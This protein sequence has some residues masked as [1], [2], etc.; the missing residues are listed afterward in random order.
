MGRQGFIRYC[1]ALLLLCGCAWAQTWSFAVSGDSRN[2]GDI[3]M[4]SIAAGA[5]QNG[6]AF[7]WHLGDFRAMYAI[8]EDIGGGKTPADLK[9]YREMAWGDFELHELGPFAGLPLFLARGNHEEA[10]G[11][12]RA[13]YVAEFSSWL[14]QPVIREQ[15]LRDD[16]TD[17]SPH[18]YYH[19]IQGGIDFIA[20]DNGSGVDFEPVQLAWFEKVLDR[21][22]RNA[23]V[24]TLVVGMHRALPDSLSAG[25]SMNDTPEGTTSGRKAY[26]DLL[27]FRKNSGKKVYVLAS[28]SHFVM[29][30]LYNTACRREHPDEILP[31]WLIGT[32]G[33][34]RYR[35]PPDH[36]AAKTAKTDVYGY[37]IGTVSPDGAVT[38]DFKQVDEDQL[39]PQV[40]QRYSKDLIHFC[41]SANRSES[42][43][44][45]PAPPPN[46][47]PE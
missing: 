17:T 32:A 20:M 24:K 22:S 47:P 4:P 18:S 8:D 2:C 29:S 38:F 14:D 6:A 34:V 28:H 41:F 7:Y 23:D 35:L 31:G 39:T 3:V 40:K 19:W 44:E 27:A 37:L 46:C 12:T 33:A 26:A 10:G 43:V 9:A 13:Q 1:A 30:D 42:V 11:Q 21:A 15:R 5:S 25:H 45:G 36:S 16:S